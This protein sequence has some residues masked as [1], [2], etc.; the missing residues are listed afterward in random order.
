MLKLVI[1]HILVVYSS[2]VTII[3]EAPGKHSLRAL[4]LVLIY[5]SGHFGPPLPLWAPGPPALP[6]LPMASGATGIQVI[7]LIVV[8]VIFHA[9]IT[10]LCGGRG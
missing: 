7:L 8:V 5:N 1:R 3:F 6:G 10:A 2:G 4:V 9:F